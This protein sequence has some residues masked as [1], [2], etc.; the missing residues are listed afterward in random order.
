M[1]ILH[2]AAFEGNIGDNASHLGF[3]NI[4]NEVVGAFDIDRLEIRKSYKNYLGDDKLEFNEGFAARANQYDVVVFGGGGFLDYWVKGATNGTTIDIKPEVFDKI[5]TNILITSVG[6]NPNR[7]VPVENYEKFKSFL[8]YVKQKDNIT[9]A[10]RNDGSVNSIERDFGREYLD[11]IVEILD[12]GYFYVPTEDHRLPIEGNYVA[13]NITDDQLSM[14]GT[15]GDNKDWYYK[16][17]EFLIEA[18]S[19]QGLKTVLVPHIHQDIEAIGTVLSKLPSGL[20]RKHTIIAPCIQTDI[21]TEL[22]F[23][24][25]KNAKFS[26]ASRYHANVCSIKFGVPT[27]GLSPLE[28]IEYTHRQLTSALTSLRI[29][30]GFASDILNLMS[31]CDFEV[32]RNSPSLDAKKMQTIDFYKDYFSKV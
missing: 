23:N 25:Y 22:S 18:L 8:D 31:N 11:T 15:L 19:K 5:S 21:G 27:I 6:C 32:I 4:L 7:V 1:K 13:L 12:H 17:I 3:L 28:R 29:K 9:I 10:L 30:K 26:I 16:E 20:V 2:I 24:I 14:R